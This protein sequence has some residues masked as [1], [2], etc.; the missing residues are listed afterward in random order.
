VGAAL[1]G[2]TQTTPNFLSALLISAPLCHPSSTVKFVLAR[3][4]PIRFQH[5]IWVLA[6]TQLAFFFSF[7]FF[8]YHHPPSVL[9]FFAFIFSVFFSLIVP[10][11]IFHVVLLLVIRLCSLV[12][13]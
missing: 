9:L 6:S 10:Y 4:G 3:P 1:G 11:F 2:F 7:F 5:Q 13:L 8:S 12:D